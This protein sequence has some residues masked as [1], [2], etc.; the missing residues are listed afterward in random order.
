MTNKL[1]VESC[2]NIEDMQVV[3]FCPLNAGESD[4]GIR[5]PDKITTFLSLEMYDFSNEVGNVIDQS[6]SESGKEV[7]LFYQTHDSMFGSDGETVHHFLGEDKEMTKCVEYIVGSLK[8][9]PENVLGQIEDNYSPVTLFHYYLNG[10]TLLVHCGENGYVEG[11]DFFDEPTDDES[12]EDYNLEKISGKVK[13]CFAG[14][15]YSD[16]SI[17]ELINAY[18]V[19]EKSASEK[20]IGIT[21]KE[22]KEDFE[23]DMF[24]RDKAEFKESGEILKEIINNFI[25]YKNALDFENTVNINPE[26]KNYFDYLISIFNK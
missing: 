4:N 6:E 5:I 8:S 22:I 11:E 23:Y 14:A 3:V 17:F 1:K 2:E 10:N 12:F 20:D 19:L 9:N 7:P 13:I 18:A 26:M 21:K 16:N 25:N 15:Q 24:L